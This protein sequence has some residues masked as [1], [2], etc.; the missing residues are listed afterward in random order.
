MRCFVDFTLASARRLPNVPDGHPCGRVHGH[1]FDVRVVLDGPVGEHS[2]WVTDFA[3]VEA[4]W[5]ARVHRP[6]DHRLLNEV[7]GLENPTSERLAQWIWRA[8]RPTLPVLAEVE[9]R[10]SSRYGCTYRGEDER[11]G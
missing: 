1:T 7:P 9:V 5:A 3:D 6:L 2:G 4:A 10:E 8:L 11:T